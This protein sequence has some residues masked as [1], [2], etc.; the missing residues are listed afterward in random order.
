MFESPNDSVDESHFLMA[1]I[2]DSR[3]L[4]TVGTTEIFVNTV[5]AYIS[6]QKLTQL[7][8]LHMTC[9]KHLVCA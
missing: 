7:N 8:N 3:G 5:S 4:T 6:R 9:N 2:I 1:E